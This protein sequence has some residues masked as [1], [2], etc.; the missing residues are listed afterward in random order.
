MNFADAI[1][2]QALLIILNVSLHAV[3]PKRCFLYN[4]QGTAMHVKRK[5]LNRSTSRKEQN[6]T[7]LHEDT[8]FS[9]F[10]RIFSY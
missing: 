2:L 1:V 4:W 7:L 3:Q 6:G 10:L 9:F 8:L 5:H